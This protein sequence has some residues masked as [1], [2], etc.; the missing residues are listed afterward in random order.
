MLLISEKVDVIGGWLILV[1][2]IVKHRSTA[3]YFP[4]V[5]VLPLE[6]AAVTVRSPAGT[7][8][9]VDV[10]AR[11]LIRRMN[12]R[13]HQQ[14]SSQKRKRRYSLVVTVPPLIFVS[15][16]IRKDAEAVHQVITPV[17][18]K[19]ISRN[20]AKCPSAVL[21]IIRPATLVRITRYEGKLA[22]A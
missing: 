6:N 1:I 5:L 15:C 20:E 21:L 19:A 12:E 9:P 14:S 7:M 16:M 3:T 22:F 8:L 11:V 18:L 13:V 4:V 17:A 2:V 10:V